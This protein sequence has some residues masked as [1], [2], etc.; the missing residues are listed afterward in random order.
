MTDQ[1][2]AAGGASSPDVAAGLL[3][4]AAGL[5]KP[6][7]PGRERL[8]AARD[9]AR[10]EAVLRAAGI[11]R[12]RRG[13]R[14]RPQ[15]GWQSLTPGHPR[16]S[17]HPHGANASPTPYPPA[18]GCLGSGRARTL[19]RATDPGGSQLRKATR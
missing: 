12:G 18:G 8:D 14:G 3:E 19:I 17:G 1:G 2:G 5:M 4:R 15:T 6:S 9:L 11:R 10:A 13:P 16:S 7:D